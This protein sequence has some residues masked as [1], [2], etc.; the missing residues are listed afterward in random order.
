[1]FPT[2]LAGYKHVHPMQVARMVL[3]HRNACRKPDNL[4]NCVVERIEIK[5]LTEK[6]AAVLG[7]PDIVEPEAFLAWYRAAHTQIKTG[8]DGR[9]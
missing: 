6:F 1:M 9:S 5:M 3:R 7:R 4:L 8:A 2:V